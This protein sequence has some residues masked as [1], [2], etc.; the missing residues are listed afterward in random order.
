MFEESGHP[1]KL[2]YFRTS[3]AMRIVASG[4]NVGINS[5]TIPTMT[6]QV[7]IK[8]AFEIR[9]IIATSQNAKDISSNVINTA[10]ERPRI[11]FEFLDKFSRERHS[12]NAARSCGSEYLKTGCIYLFLKEKK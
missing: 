7:G 12:L 11:D 8:C 4:P 9:S 5:R 6:A 2:N 3:K 1:V 10:T